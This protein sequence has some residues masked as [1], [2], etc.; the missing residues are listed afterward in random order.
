MKNFSIR[1]ASGS[2]ILILFLSF[3]AF[4]QNT[5]TVVCDK[6]DNT[7]K[8]V[9]SNKRS[10]NYVPIKGG[11]PFRQVAQKWIDEKYAT[12][13][14]NPEKVLEE[15]QNQ[16][17]NNTIQN[18]SNT[19]NQQNQSTTGPATKP[20][21]PRPM[22]RNTSF[23]FSG[24]FSNLGEAFRLSD[25]MVPGFEFGMER[26]FGRDLYFGMGAAFDMFFPDVS[27][28]DNLS[29]YFFRVPGFIGYRMKRN[30]M[31]IIYEGGVH[32]NTSFMSSD[33]GHTV[34]GL[35]SADNSFNFMGRIKIGSETVM[36]EVGS[37]IWFTEVF[38]DFEDYNMS[39]I[40]AALRFYF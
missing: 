6:T 7:V 20:L 27:S 29:V 14:C 15:I 34:P 16:N 24:K 1:I 31:M 12:T 28:I 3:N 17:D 5:F 11:F 30:N 40:Y 18:Q 22:Y 37:E 9:E 35:I 32:L 2:I 23:I 33:E 38:E 10:P 13:E 21:K 39:T 19:V 25:N 26:L 36:L 4:S 8:V